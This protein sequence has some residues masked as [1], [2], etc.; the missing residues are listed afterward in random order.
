MKERV[1]KVHQIAKEPNFVVTECGLYPHL[2]DLFLVHDLK[3]DLSEV[4]KPFE[5]VPCKGCLAAIKE[6]RREKT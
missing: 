5:V 2:H 6:T 3:G 4:N 1:S